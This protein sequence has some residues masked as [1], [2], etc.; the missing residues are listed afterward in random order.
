MKYFL[1]SNHLTQD[2]NDCVARVTQLDNV[3]YD[4]VIKLTTRR[5]L[6]LT[7]TELISAVN[8]IDYTIM[9]VLSSGRGVDTPFARYRPSISGLFSSKDDFFDPTRH[10]IKINCLVGR[11]I[12]VNANEILLEKVKYTA[13][14]PFIERI[15]DYSTQEENDTI[16]PG[17][18]AEIDGELLK[19]DLA[20]PLQGLF[21]VRNGNT[22]KVQVIFRNLPS[23]L[24]FNI[25]ATLTVGEYQLEIRNKTNKNDVLLKNHLLSSLLTVK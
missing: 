18:A 2:P 24:I 15:L 19:I 25:P 7:D 9:D 1:Y 20:D 13:S 22:T 3:S 16:T 6:S 23:E 10:A 4:D 14:S 12:K 17:G 11:D 8:E 5:G 21:F